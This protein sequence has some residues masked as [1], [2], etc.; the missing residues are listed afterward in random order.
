MQQRWFPYANFHEILDVPV[1]MSFRSKMNSQSLESTTI[2]AA[3]LPR[4]R[5]I[6]DK[7]WDEYREKL[8]KLYVEEDIS[9][10][11]IIDTMTK[12]HS[13]VIT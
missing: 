6:P 4:A 10:K 2:A 7:E 9:R 3:Q 13:F 5:R 11:D 8:V 1:S 12:E